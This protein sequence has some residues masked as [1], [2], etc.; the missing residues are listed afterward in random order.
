MRALQS[1]LIRNLHA[2]LLAVRQVT[3]ENPWK[4]DLDI[5]KRSQNQGSK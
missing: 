2:I 1:R 4:K 5:Y 3:H